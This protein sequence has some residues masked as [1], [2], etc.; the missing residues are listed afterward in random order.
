[1]SSA[2]SFIRA[3]TAEILYFTTKIAT[4]QL[5]MFGFK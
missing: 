1:M 3:F 5:T 4:I 2:F